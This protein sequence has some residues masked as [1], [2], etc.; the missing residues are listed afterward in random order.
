MTIFEASGVQGE[1]P[2]SNIFDAASNVVPM[3]DTAVDRAA[4]NVENAIGSKPEQAAAAIPIS[5]QLGIPPE[6]VVNDY[7]TFSALHEKKV[8]T[9]AVV[10]DKYL[11]DYLAS[12][13]MA[14]K[15]SSKDYLALSLAARDSAKL[16]N[17]AVGSILSKTFEGFKYGIGTGQLG[18][19]T[20]INWWDS[21]VQ[22]EHPGLAATAA[23]ITGVTDPFEAIMRGLSGAIFGTTAGVAEAWRQATGQDVSGVADTIAQAVQDPALAMTLGPIG[24]IILPF[25][26]ILHNARMNRSARAL[27]PYLVEGKVPP[28]GVDA[29]I[30]ALHVEQAKSDAMALGDAIKS[31]A[32]TQTRE[33]S[34]DLYHKFAEGVVG[35]SQIGISADAVRAVYGDKVPAPGDGLLGFVPDLQAKLALAEATGGDVKVP[36][37]DYLTHITPELGKQLND[38]VRVRPGGMTLEETKRPLEEPTVTG[39]PAQDM[40]FAAGL[41]PKPTAVLRA[42]DKSER[43]GD[44]THHFAIDVKGEPAAELFI[45]EEGGPGAKRL[46]ID[47]M[48]A[49]NGPGALGGR[50]VRELLPQIKA[51]FPEAE[52]LEGLRVSGAREAAGGDG[53]KVTIDLRKVKGIEPR[54]EAEAKPTTSAK[55]LE[56]P[57]DATT[58]MEDRPVFEDK[59]PGLT[60][61]LTERYQKLLDKRASEDEAAFRAK[62][63]AE[64]RRKQSREWKA[65]R[66]TFRPQA[67][68]VVA[69]RPDVRTLQGLAAREIV[70][71]KQNVPLRF[72]DRL[73]GS[74]P[75]HYFAKEGIDPSSLMEV[76]NVNSP[77]AV[78]AKV[79][80]LHSAWKESKKPWPEFQRKL[81][82]DEMNRLMAEKHGNLEQNILDAAL[83]RVLSDTQ[84]ELLHEETMRAAIEAGEQYP[85]KSGPVVDAIKERMKE[86]PWKDVSAEESLAEVRRATRAMEEA[87]VRGDVKEQF[88][89]SQRK[90]NAFIQ[91][92]EARKIEKVRDQ[93]LKLARK[94]A[95]REVSGIDADYVRA[96]H[97]IL[98]K[99]ELPFGRR[100]EDL[101]KEMQATPYRTLEDFVRT[102]N[103]QFNVVG[104]D[105]PV[106]DFLME[107]GTKPFEKMTVDELQGL[108]QSMKVLDD[109]GR[110]EQKV[111]IAGQK[112][113]RKEWIEQANQQLVDRF[114]IKPATVKPKGVVSKFKQQFISATHS[115]DTIF[116]RFDARDPE[117]MFTE[118][119]IYPAAKALN[120]EERLL[121]E[122]SRDYRAIGEVKDPKQ[123][124]EHNFTDPLTGKKFEGFNRSTLATIINNIGNKYN[125]DRMAFTLGTT[126]EELI[127]WVERVSTREDIDRAQALGKV[128]DKGKG[129]SDNVYRNIY[130]Q[131]PES[132]KLQPLTLHGKEYEGWYHPIIPDAE[133]AAKDH[134]RVPDDLTK[135]TTFWP[136]TPNSYTKRRTGMFEHLSLNNEMVPVALGQM[137]HDIAVRDFVY[138]AAKIINDA[139]FRRGVTRTYGKE[140]HDLM[141]VWLHRIAGGKSYNP[142]ALSAGA[143]FSNMLRQNVMSTYIAFN[144]G[145]VQKHGPT[146]FVM[147]AQEVGYWPIVKAMGQMYSDSVASLFGRDPALGETISKFIHSASEEIQRRDRNWQESLAGA[148][149]FV[150]GNLTLRERIQQR[151]AQWVAFSDMISA[152]P[153]WWAK[154]QETLKRTEGDHARAVQ[155]ADAS[156]RRAHGST[157][158]VSR[159]MIASEG[160]A[161]G[162]WMTS[163]YGFFGANMQRKIEILHDLNDAYKLGKQK[164]IGQAAKQIPKIAQKIFSYVIFPAIVEEAVT[165]QFTK[166]GEGL[167]H[168]ALATVLQGLT[169]SIIGVRDIAWSLGHGQEPST[170]LLSAP[171]HDMANLKRDITR[172]APFSREHAGKMIQDTLTVMGDLSGVSPKPVARALR[173]GHDVVRGV[174]HPRTLGDVYRGLASGQQELRSH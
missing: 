139:E 132:I 148:H 11:T 22:A 110:A 89:Q 172:G 4:A 9:A 118:M 72:Y 162:P 126:P 61:A 131:A 143:R 40:R 97:S 169:N 98:Q 83:E 41:D 84:A 153:L 93:T 173:Y 14:A 35:D 20:G 166:S 100:P 129:M 23:S 57:V 108:H 142:T 37:A 121:R 156:V 6:A 62:R 78:M 119:F 163:L 18:D 120:D 28:V 48:E 38:F 69:S 102:K 155:E 109:F 114:G 21:K 117:G 161:L 26:A 144:P 80:G 152:K 29:N 15:V 73:E 136:S 90:E 105:L 45:T 68:E 127:A 92:T 39:N 1:A 53:A 33:L 123:A 112:Q 168:L 167:G 130:N 46:Y 104:V 16:N 145:T 159:P 49:P 2:K 128:F 12:N 63:I 55:Q 157:S 59:A 24:E 99:V 111:E 85:I 64:E 3:P 115:L 51:A 60:K 10:S 31:A 42:M 54:P 87:A 32:S 81:I 150:Q 138:N 154:Y 58:R 134:A 27:A 149:D 135:P 165:G 36:L 116:Q 94:Y 52:T 66:E 19:W 96:I 137:V 47:D 140:Y 77:E 79:A 34:P 151:G 95:K 5:A 124:I 146:A 76:F 171:L 133:R 106:A 91:A 170:G 174:Q 101:L 82:G 70:F 25:Q 164:E 71:A 158:L 74:L 75:D 107:P 8:N 88:R 13:P 67:A 86:I 122:F 103:D 7:D 44:I 17:S 160:G 30:D 43:A 50:S 113:D 56:L 141:K 147:S 65:E 125:L